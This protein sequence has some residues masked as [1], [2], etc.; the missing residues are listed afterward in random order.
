MMTGLAMRRP[1]LAALAVLALAACSR[2]VEVPLS[3]T[4]PLAGTKYEIAVDGVQVASR[5]NPSTPTLMASMEFSASGTLKGDAFTPPKLTLKVLR[6][7]GWREFPIEWSYKPS[8]E[9][10]RQSLSERRPLISTVYM[11]TIPGALV[12]LWVDNRKGPEGA[13]KLGPI[14]LAIPAG[15]A[16]SRDVDACDAPIP[17]EYDGAGVGEIPAVSSAPA[18]MQTVVIEPTGR[19][20]YMQY[21]VWYGPESIGGG[22]TKPV[23]VS[24]AKLH[25][26]PKLI[27]YMFENPPTER[28]ALQGEFPTASVLKDAACPMSGARRK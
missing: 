19:R 8:A 15:K 7:C 26:F 4:L 5:F 20:C 6:G 3:V 22:R 25:D 17:V 11:P 24:G 21:D 18:A 14:R 16:T 23:L 12:S 2:P 10:I 28:L 27:T 9:A 13:L 1:R